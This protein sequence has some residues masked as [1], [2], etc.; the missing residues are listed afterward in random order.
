MIAIIL[1]L[2]VVCAQAGTPV[3]T[4]ASC[5]SAG[6]GL[7]C[8]A[9][10]KL[11]R[12]YSSSFSN[13]AACQDTT[14]KKLCQ[15]SG[16]GWTS[17]ACTNVV[18]PLMYWNCYEGYQW[19]S[20][21][22]CQAC[23]KGRYRGYNGDNS[24]ARVFGLGIYCDACPMG[25]YAN[26]EGLA[27]CDDCAAGKYQIS[28]EQGSADGVSTNS[29]CVQCKNCPQGYY[30]GSNGAHNCQACGVGKQQGS[31][32]KASSG[33]CTDCSPGKFLFIRFM[34]LY[35]YIYISSNDRIFYFVFCETMGEKIVYSHSPFFSR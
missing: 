2:A 20:S 24:K 13:H 31:T 17:S 35:I 15:D 22:Y 14:G 6:S 4:G 18:N 7:V 10:R 34:S 21:L 5:A 19:D 32:G 26:Q 9:G 28:C 30:Q 16:N 3:T 25:K 33:D 1:A 12:C 8:D 11:Y 27:V 23:K 29:G